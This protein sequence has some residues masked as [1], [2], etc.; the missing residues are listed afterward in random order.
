MKEN[1]TNEIAV[2]THWTETEETM[3]DCSRA[4]SMPYWSEDFSVIWHTIPNTIFIVTTQESFLYLGL[5]ILI[6][7]ITQT[8]LT[9]KLQ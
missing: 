2:S 5:I 3:L 6:I 7:V 9:L 4:E 8:F 1:F